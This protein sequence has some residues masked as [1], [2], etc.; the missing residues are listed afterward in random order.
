MAERK[1]SKRS[2]DS[3]TNVHPDLVRV[4]AHALRSLRE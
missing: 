3:L 2:I 1:F 4:I